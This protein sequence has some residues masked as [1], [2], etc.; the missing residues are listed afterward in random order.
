MSQRRYL[1]IEI[2]GIPLIHIEWG[3]TH[4]DAE[5]AYQDCQYPMTIGF[6]QPDADQ[7]Q[8]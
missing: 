8:A 3:P 6:R 5:G 4:D 7:V 2:L 1:H